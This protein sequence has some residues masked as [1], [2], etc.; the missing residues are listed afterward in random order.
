MCT[1]EVRKWLAFIEKKVKIVP[2]T[3]NFLWF[4]SLM[5]VPTFDSHA[6]RNIIMQL[7]T[8]PTE[9]M[10][11][12]T[13]E[14]KGWCKDEKELA[15]KISEAAA[16][17]ANALG[18][19]VLVGIADEIEGAAKF[20][21]CPYQNVRTDWITRR[22]HDLTYPPVE[23]TVHDISKLAQEIS[24]KPSAIVYAI[25]APRTNRIGGH[26]ITGGLSKIRAARNAVH[27]ILRKMTALKLAFGAVPAI[28][29]A[30]Q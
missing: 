17:L 9:L 11:S 26:Q 3:L 8:V 1:Y 2:A 12:E 10:E 20:S 27:T 6:I 15:I 19:I 28:Y 5:G 21:H 14:I 25:S 18:G 4:S 13:L 16:C 29:R 7:C 23:I 24:G 22:I 30:V